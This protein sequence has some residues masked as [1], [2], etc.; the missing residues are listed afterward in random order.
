FENSEKGQ[1]E[2]LF[3][4]MSSQQLT[5]RIEI[6]QIGPNAISMFGHQVKDLNHVYI[7]SVGKQTISL[8]NDEGVIL[9]TYDYSMESNTEEPLSFILQQ[10]TT[11]RL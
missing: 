2:I 4:D 7:T 10:A 5:K 11:I 9:K 6:Q 3:Y 8:V 1:H